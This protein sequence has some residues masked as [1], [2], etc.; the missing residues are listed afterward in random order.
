MVDCTHVR[1]IVAVVT[2]LAASA[3]ASP[4][5]ET[6]VVASSDEAFRSALGDALAPTGMRV[7]ATTDEAPSVAELSITARQIA[8]REGAT[9][10]V[11]LIFATDK[12]TLV[13][14]DRDVDRV[15]V[16]E[17]PYVAPLDPAKAAEIARMARTMLRT[18][19]VSPEI[20]LPVP[21]VEEAR[22]VRADLE[23]TAI[24]IVPRA[25]T[26][27]I[28]AAIGLR[29][30]AAAR[31]A[32]L[33]GRLS[34]LWRP[35]ALGLGAH[36]SLATRGELD[37]TGFTGEISDDSIAVTMHYPVITGPGV[38]VLAAGGFAL[39]ALS[40]EGALDGDAVTDR[41]YDP[42]VRLGATANFEFGRTLDIGIGVSA[43][44]LLRRQRYASGMAEVLVVPRVQ[45][46]T[47]LIVTFR[48]L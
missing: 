30:G 14:Y 13:T 10:T 35:D 11:W 23:A 44:G 29:V 26:V 38:H 4:A 3:V 15:L 39:H 8:E 36:A 32:G 6:V 18:L 31:D 37:T 22:I 5:P 43:D 7:I 12:T 20:D 33:D 45:L 46:T 1:A 48:V 28:A 9:S 16:R 2:A 40:I 19:R 27:A 17:V 21:R 34:V 41:R 42:A 47:G 25:R 24:A